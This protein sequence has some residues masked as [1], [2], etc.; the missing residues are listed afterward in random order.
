MT[1]PAEARDLSSNLRPSKKPRNNW[2]LCGLM[3]CRGGGITRRDPIW[4]CVKQKASKVRF[5]YF[6]LASC[7]RS[8][9]AFGSAMPSTKKPE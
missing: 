5:A 6:L 3:Y 7:P 4:G 2:G 8:N 9:E 1:I